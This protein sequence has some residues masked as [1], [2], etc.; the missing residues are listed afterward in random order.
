MSKRQNVKSEEV[1]LTDAH[2]RARNFL[3]DAEMDGLLE[4]AKKGCHGVNLALYDSYV[5]TGP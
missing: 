4:A 3:S 2:E 5:V 1:R